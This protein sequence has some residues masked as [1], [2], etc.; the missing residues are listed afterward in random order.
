MMGEKAKA[1]AAC[2]VLFRCEISQQAVVKRLV[3]LLAIASGGILY[4]LW[5]PFLVCHCAACRCTVYVLN[6]CFA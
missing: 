6:S 5:G 4:S 1:T 3:V 2:A